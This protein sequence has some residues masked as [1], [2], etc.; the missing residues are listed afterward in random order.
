[1]RQA[2]LPPGDAPAH[3]LGAAWTACFRAGNFAGA[4]TISDQVLAGRDRRERDDPR[5]PYHLRWV[6]DG[7]SVESQRVLVRCY[8]GLGDTLQFARFLPELRRRV[9]H[10]ALEVQPELL[11]L[12]QDLPYLDEVVGFDVKA[13]LAWSG[14][15]VEIMEL[16]HLLRADATQISQDASWIRMRDHVEPLGG[17][18]GLCWSAGEWNPRRSVPLADLLVACRRPGRHLVSLQRGAA[19]A[20]AQDPAFINPGDHDSSTMATA[21]HIRR[22]EI[23][24]TVDTMVA[25]LAGA[26]GH[27]C[28]LLLQSQPDW[29]WPEHSDCSATRTI[30]YPAT[31]LFHQRRAGDWAAPLQALARELTD[32]AMGDHENLC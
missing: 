21:S 30:W 5:K 29:R 28:L 20:Q 9:S 24:V 13:P 12:F 32:S 1:M 31:R 19:A 18:V 17:C 25:H 14:V 15:E 8:H 10:L 3:D 7:R 26:L 23:V 22:T 27:R 4:W 11:P 6:W 16:A 2:G